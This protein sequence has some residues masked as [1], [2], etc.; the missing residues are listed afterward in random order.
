MKDSSLAQKHFQIPLSVAAGA[1]AAANRQPRAQPAQAPPPQRPQEGAAAQDRQ[2]AAPPPDPGPAG[3]KGRGKG[4]GGKGKGVG[5]RAQSN[6]RTPDGRL[7]C[8]RYQRNK[9]PGNCGKAHVCLV[10]NGAHPASKCHLRPAQAAPPG[11][12]PPAGDAGGTPLR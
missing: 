3:A 7:K 11:G 1:A 2:W 9:C 4:R 6:P 10:C 8:F 5:W 12:G